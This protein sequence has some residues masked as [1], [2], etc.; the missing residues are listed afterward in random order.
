MSSS[1]A[2]GARTEYGAKGRQA[3][4]ALGG[5]A[6]CEWEAEAAV[7]REAEW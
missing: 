6:T 7:R 2:P 4:V 3:K 1:K 5:A